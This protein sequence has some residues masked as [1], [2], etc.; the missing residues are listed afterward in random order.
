[1]LLT[2]ASFQFPL[3]VVN[4]FVTTIEGADPVNVHELSTPEVITYEL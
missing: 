1:M 3:R 4:W 2:D